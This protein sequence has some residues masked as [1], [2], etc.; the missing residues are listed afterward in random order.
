MEK[1]KE[2]RLAW[3]F[4]EH[5]GK[6]VFLTGKAGTGKT[7]FLKTLK[8]YSRKRMVVVAPTGVAAINAGGVTIHSFFQLPLSSY[9]PGAKFDSK[10]TYSNE[11]RKI[12]RTM[13]LLVIDEISMVR[14]DVLDAIDVVMRRFRE[15]NK[16]FGGVQLVMIGDL[17][18]LTPVV[19][20]DESALLAQ[21]Y[22]TPYFFGSNAL[23]GVDYVTIELR[24]VYRQEDASFIGIL[25]DIRDGK[26]TPQDLQTLNSR[27]IPTF[28]P[29]PEEGYI[30]LTTHNRMADSY[31]EREL[32]SL[33]S[34]AFTFGAEIEGDF[35][36]YSYPTDQ[37]LILKVGAQ[38]MF[39]KNDAGGRYYNGRIGRVTYVDEHQIL[40]KCEGDEKAIDVQ[41]E[42][43][44]NTKYKLNEADKQIEAEVAGVFRQY[45]L[46]LAWAITIHKSQGLTFDH[47]IIDAHLSFASGQVYVALSRCKTLEGLVLSSPITPPSIINDPRVTTYVASQ[48]Q[49]ARQS[50]SRLPALMDEYYRQLL[51]E[52]FSF[53]QL[54]G[55][56]SVLDRVMQEFFYGKTPLT[57]V[58]H[59][60][61]KDLRSSLEPLSQKWLGVIG[62]MTNDALHAPDFLERVKRGAAYFAGM[63]TDILE[64]TVEKTRRLTSDNK[65]IEKRLESAYTDVHDIWMAK[66]IVLE[67]I[68]ANGFTPQGYL[69]VK[70]EAVI[71][72]VEDNGGRATAARKANGSTR[73]GTAARAKTTAKKAKTDTRQATLDLYRLGKT[74][75]EIASERNLAETTIFNHLVYFVEK[76][77][78]E[79]EAILPPK[80]FEEIE[81]VIKRVGIADGAA[82]IKALCPPE[83]TWGEL[84]LVIN[85]VKK[86]QEKKA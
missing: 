7:T 67:S 43:W 61:L 59:N 78:L 36:A 66:R 81:K 12:M 4:V 80:H 54:I 18:Q 19:T 77:R 37:N 47:A 57:E 49:R 68:A 35:P 8:K 39:L 17:R 69:K 26:P 55:A 79:Q 15:H 24:H 70:Q 29:K 33:P 38:V 3:D 16:P 63:I 46:R 71:A 45:P 50:I 11:K 25:N 73:K 40:V 76:G 62:G 72:A 6:S 13:D 42:E 14:S 1:N 23:K 52:V 64:E 27:Y 51:M 53:G 75:A 58:H 56:E 9:F 34:R 2:L 84:R 86:R 31:N 20:N 83:I 65:M 30:R 10:Y 5:T 74:I 82:P 48:E 32:Q 41:K 28:R 21:Y 22:D 44:E 85:L 60:V